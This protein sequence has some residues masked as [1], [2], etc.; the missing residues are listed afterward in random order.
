M[1][2][3]VEQIEVS[4]HVLTY[5]AVRGNLGLQKCYSAE[6]SL[7][8]KKRKKKKS[9]LLR[10]DA[11]NLGGRCLLVLGSSCATNIIKNIKLRK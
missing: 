7:H 3:R 5:V 8:T 11:L 6:T 10:D 9:G 1:W 2:F 4:I